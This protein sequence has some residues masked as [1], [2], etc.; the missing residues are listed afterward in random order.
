VR[1]G[2]FRDVESECPRTRNYLRCGTGKNCRFADDLHR[3]ILAAEALTTL[4]PEDYIG[5]LGAP[6]LSAMARLRSPSLITR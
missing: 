2:T 3:V 6:P 4:A 5:P 1:R